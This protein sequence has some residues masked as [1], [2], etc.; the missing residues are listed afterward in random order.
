MEI[1]WIAFIVLGLV[2]GFVASK[3]VNKTGSGIFLDVAIGVV[4]AL[5]GGFIGVKLHQGGLED[6]WSPWT[7]LLSI[8]GAVIVL[9]IYN[10]VVRRV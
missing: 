6:F 4:G 1:G 9:L 10:A 3:I 5:V 2:S 8:A 7:W